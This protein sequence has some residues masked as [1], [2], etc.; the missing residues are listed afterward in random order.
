[1]LGSYYIKMHACLKKFGN[2]FCENMNVSYGITTKNIC[3]LRH[4][5][6][7][8]QLDSYM[9]IQVPSCTVHLYTSCTISYSQLAILSLARSIM[10]LN[11]TTAVFQDLENTVKQNLSSKTISDF[12]VLLYPPF[13]S[14]FILYYLQLDSYICIYKYFCN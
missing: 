4:S 13:I 8:N 7:Y 9:Y 6:I 12:K 11:L 3:V 2:G 10:S 1:M 5:Y 14:T